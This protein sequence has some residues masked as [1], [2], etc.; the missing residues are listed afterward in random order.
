MSLHIQGKVIDHGRGYW[1][2][3]NSH[4]NDDYFINSVRSTIT[5]TCNQ[6]FDS[7]GGLWDV[8][9]FKVKELSIN[10]GKKKKKEK[11]MKRESLIKKIDSI[12]K[13]PN[14]IN[15]I[16]LRSDLFQAE[17]SLNEVLTQVTEGAI[18]R[19]RVQ[20]TEQGERSTRY[21]FGLEKSRAK[22]KLINS[23]IDTDDNS[24]T[25]QSAIS[26][27]VV[28]FYQKLYTSTNPCP[29]NL[30]N[31]VECSTVSSISEEMSS[32]LDLPLCQAELG[33]VVGK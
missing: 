2:F 30:N 7:Y 20:W 19:S 13:C 3:N 21:F 17:A 26:D 24:L 8:I 29:E 5:E 12:K 31:Y 28:K 4:L 25:D 27:H 33:L 23:L 22:K 16:N 9:K 32:A 6:D 1:K 18:T 11:N 10:H 15:D 14:F